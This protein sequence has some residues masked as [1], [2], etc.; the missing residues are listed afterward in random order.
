MAESFARTSTPPIEEEFSNTTET[1]RPPDRRIRTPDAA[2]HIFE[3]LRELADTKS[4]MWARIQGIYDRNPPYRQEELDRQ[5]RGYQTN[6][7]TGE[8]EA[9]ID[10]NTAAAHEAIIE[11]S[12]L[13]TSRVDPFFVTG[14]DPSEASN[15]SLIIDE[16]YTRTLHAWEGFFY[17]CDL[18]TKESFKYGLG[19]QLWPDEFDWRSR[20]YRSSALLFPPRSRNIVEELD[21]IL[22]RDEIPVRTLF[23][24][25]EDEEAAR[26]AGWNVPHVRDVIAATYNFGASAN[27]ADEEYQISIWESV[28]QKIKNNDPE[29]ERQ[30]FA[31]VKVVHFAVQEADTGEVSHLII[32]ESEVNGRQDFMFESIRRFPKMSSLLWLLTFDN[33][34]GYLRSIKGMGHRAFM[35]TDLSNRMFCT[36][37]DGGQVASSLLVQPASGTDLNRLEMVRLG[38]VTVV[39]PGLN[40]IQSSFTPPVN[41]LISL[42]QMSSEL[43]NNNLGVFRA[44]SEN[45]LVRP[46]EKTAAQVQFEASKEAR[47]E[48]N[49]ATHRYLAWDRWHE[50]T[51]RRLTDKEYLLPGM[52]PDEALEIFNVSGSIDEVFDEI[53]IKRPGLKEALTFVFNCVKRGVPLNLFFAP[54]AISVRATRAIGL[55]S[56]S[57]KRDA[58]NQLMQARSSMDEVGRRNTEREW[59]ASLVGGY[60]SVDRFYAQINRDEIPSNETTIATLE[61]NDF[62]EGSRLPVGVDQSHSI[63]L[64]VHSATAVQF[65]QQFQTAPET[66]NLPRVL[67][68][69]T[70]AIPHMQAHLELLSVDPTRK[71]QVEALQQMM[72]GIIR[73]FGAIRQNV[74]QL[75]EKQQQLRAQQE[76]EL[77]DLRNRADE[78]EAKIAV[79]KHRID[80]EMELK[81][82][83]TEALNTTRFQ[84]ME[85]SILAKA[86]QVA[87][88]IV[89]EQQRTQAEIA[90]KQA[91]DAQP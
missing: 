45:P 17:N 23:E 58:L 36:L 65:I 25:I 67:Q 24:Q 39:P 59:T 76:K 33:G 77:E 73:G 88:E 75:Q 84:K 61:N 47:F 38:A 9:I 48:K 34:D 2:Y 79:E 15:F 13:I 57:L 11:V 26:E 69:L 71:D 63:H 37:M 3:D 14:S 20:A 1:G 70:S 7:N 54:D 60:S 16:E 87:A 4:R 68:F 28:Q 53:K 52:T 78:T 64:R 21:L 50:E 12:S 19:F 82:S 91:K 72:Q 55:G 18:A 80:R 42:R 35:H 32:S 83:E 66:L 44:R 43:L 29:A 51:F 22:V 10:A 56:E 40:V 89:L 31:G 49:R 5:G 86:Q 90:S 46:A 81:R 27:R 6:V 41:H 62:A 8:M 30:E 74:E 85:A